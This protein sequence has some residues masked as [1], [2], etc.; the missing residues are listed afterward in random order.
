[1]GLTQETPPRKGTSGV[2]NM[3]DGVT[4]S[5]AEL[6]R[7]RDEVLQL[8]HERAQWV[9]ECTLNPRA[10]SYQTRL[11]HSPCYHSRDSLSADVVACVHVSMKC[12]PLQRDVQ[13]EFE[14]ALNAADSEV[15]SSTARITVS[16]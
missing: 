10:V 16:T 14:E 7:L 5:S 15:Q 12:I 11:K 13:A 2:W 1:M 3:A 4:T 9:R 8:R 6:E